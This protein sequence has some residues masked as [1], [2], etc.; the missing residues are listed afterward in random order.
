MITP[1]FN[2]YLNLG[3][4][5]TKINRI[6][7]YLLQKCFKGLVKSVVEARRLGGQNKKSTV[8]A[9]TSKLLSNSSYGYQIM[10]RSKHT[11]TKYLDEEK[12]N[13]A[14]NSTVFE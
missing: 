12:T 13:R 3:L 1:F 2:F 9:E 5:C 7:E 4:Q 14:I 10:D 6:G 8:I 11:Q